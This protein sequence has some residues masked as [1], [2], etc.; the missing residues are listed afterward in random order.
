RR[1]MG[2][3][4][5]SLRMTSPSSGRQPFNASQARASRPRIGFDLGFARHDRLAGQEPPSGGPAAGADRQIGRTD[6]ALGE[7]DEAL[8]HRAIFK[9][10]ERDRAGAPTDRD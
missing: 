9:T 1:P 5:L 4:V 2:R 7:R 10:M 8:L 3:G 6:A